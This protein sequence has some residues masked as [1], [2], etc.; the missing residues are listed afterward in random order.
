M[1]RTLILTIGRA[2]APQA[3]PPG[4]AD[5]HPAVPAPCRRLPGGAAQRHRRAGEH[6]AGRHHGRDHGQQLHELLHYPGAFSSES[7]L[8][9]G[10]SDY[11]SHAAGIF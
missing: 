6:R 9:W 2:S 8:R 3:E 10:L 11:Y 7:D 5:L 4:R 1:P